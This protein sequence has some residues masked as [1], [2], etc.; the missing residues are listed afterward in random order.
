MR[1]TLAAAVLAMGTSGQALPVTR[2]AGA[3]GQTASGVSQSAPQAPAPAAQLPPLAPTQIDPRNATLDS[4]RTI[5]LSYLEP[6]PIRDVLQ[7]LVYGTSFTIALDAD[8]TGNFV[9]DLKHLT[10]RESLTTLLKPLGLD[11]DVQGTVITVSRH[12]V[13]TRAY[14]LDVLNVRRALQ[15][16]SG[17]SDGSAT[18]T[19]T[20]NADDVFDEI[21]DGVTMLLSDAGRV[22]VDRR[23]GLAQVT[24]YPERLD[25]VGLYI[26]TLHERSSRQVHLEAQ[27][28]EITLKDAA[29]VNWAAVR[30]KLGVPGS[31]PEAGIGMD[32]A[33]VRAALADQGDIRDIAA[34]DV[35]TLNNE[36]AI[37]HA[38]TPGVSTLTL[39]VVPQISSDGIIQLSIAPAFEERTGDNVSGTKRPAMRVAESDTIVRV[40]DGY[41]ALVV[42][43]LSRPQD[44][45][46]K[47]Q[48]RSWSAMF[49]APPKVTGHAV[50][51]VLLRA[52]IVGAGSVG[53]GSKR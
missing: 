45:A 30:E 37:L 16:V 1:L 21:A 2:L 7:L 18:V 47:S 40:A 19:S 42:P 20:V 23:A 25:R 10:L 27:V 48:A 28:L 6:T 50:L 29:S 39:T 22:H 17:P 12:R 41:T 32:P 3:S 33:A 35:T 36:P 11:F 8:V 34:P 15:R 52:T 46:L 9:G 53:V 49:S 4:P 43:G 44:L 51:I 14:E 26:E 24:D 13:E 31:A 38:G 5:S